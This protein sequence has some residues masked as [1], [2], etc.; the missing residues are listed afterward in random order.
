MKAAIIV[1]T[2]CPE[3]LHGKGKKWIARNIQ[4]GLDSPQPMTAMAEKRSP[5]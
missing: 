2:P 1:A 3:S 5:G 4:Q